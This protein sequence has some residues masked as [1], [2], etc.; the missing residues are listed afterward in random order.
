MGFNETFL[1]WETEYDLF[2]RSVIGD[3]QFYPYI[4]RDFTNTV[5]SLYSRED[6]DYFKDP[7][8]ENENRVK[9]FLRLIRRTEKTGIRNPDVLFLCHGRR[10]LENGLYVCPFTDYLA[11]LY[12]NSVS[13]ERTHRHRE[14]ARTKNLVYADRIWALAFLYHVLFRTFRKKDYVNLIKQAESILGEPLAALEEALQVKIRK[15]ALY[16]RIAALTCFYR[17]SRKRYVRFL[18]RLQP[19]VI[20]EVVGKSFEAKLINEIASELSIPTVELQHSILT[21]NSLYPEG[22]KE[23]QFPDYLLT[24]SDYWSDFA[25]LPIPQDH[26]IAVGQN[27]FDCRLKKYA[28]VLAEK[29]A[30]KHGI[31]V[32][33]LS[34]LVYGKELSRFAVRFAEL[35]GKHGISVVYKLHP[36]EFPDWREQYPELAVSGLTVVD[37]LEK[38]IYDIF[39]ENDVQV[40]VKSTA[41][42]EGIGFGLS[43]F[44][45]EHEMVDDMRRVCEEGYA[46]LV[47]TPEELLQGIL[48]LKRGENAAA[49]EHFWKSGAA[50]NT[51]NVIDGLIRQTEIQRT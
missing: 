5:L 16:R 38:G 18:K 46:S 19:R 10:V 51:K 35:A 26:V 39:A 44:V 30:G 14:P 21:Q 22:V 50:E 15:K 23:R 20:V 11:D 9:Q 31:R 41:L 1:A 49:A 33:F 25:R 29:A 7:G 3:F 6:H 2:G 28:P 40:G 34:G 4:R 13:L 8:T 43:T 42:Y 45:M 27:Q 47:R 32:A 12:P 37:T 24:W 36:V 17:S 48:N